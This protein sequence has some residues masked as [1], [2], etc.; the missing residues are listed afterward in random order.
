VILRLVLAFSMFLPFAAFAGDVGIAYEK[1]FRLNKPPVRSSSGDWIGLGYE[2]EPAIRPLDYYF[3]GDVRFYFQDDGA[4]NYSLREAYIQYHNE[5][6]KLKIGR[7]ILDWN[8]N[9]KYWALGY[10]NALQSFSLLGTEEEGL[11]QIVYTQAIGFMEFDLVF[12]YLF[13]PQLNPEVQIKNGE[14]ESKSEWVRLPPKRTV[15]SGVEVPIYYAKADFDINDII[16]NKSVGGNIRFKWDDGAFSLFSIYKPENKVR[17]NASAYYDNVVLNKVVVESDPTVNHHAY[18][19]SQI[20]QRFGDVLG[21]IGFSYVDPNARLGKDFPLEI[22]NARRVF[23]SDFFTINPRYEREGYAHG[24]INLDRSNYKLS[25][26]YIQLITHNS[27]EQD[28]FF[29]DA[30]KWRSTIGGSIL[31]LLD[32]YLSLFFDLKYDL[33][34]EDNI[35]KTEAKYFFTNKLSM[36]VGAEVL[37][38]PKDESY[39]SAYR[40]NDTVYSAVGFVF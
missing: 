36:T 29:S 18:Y 9:E 33:R 30:V 21:R 16:F 31:Y 4:F 37:K 27:R 35:V 6:F 40:T 25:L 34:R 32:D 23:T 14:V 15:I 13:I 8:T 17:V 1:F 10:L 38:A 7:Q 12:S 2:S 26:N 5:D 20:Y 28:D 3:L 24:S 22:R 11:S 19:G 39:W